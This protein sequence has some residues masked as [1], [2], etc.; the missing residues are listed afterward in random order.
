M[1]E[2]EPVTAPDGTRLYH[3]AWT[4]WMWCE[5]E[6]TVAGDFDAVQDAGVCPACGEALKDV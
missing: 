3:Y 2:R 1:S 5:R 6:M 4:S